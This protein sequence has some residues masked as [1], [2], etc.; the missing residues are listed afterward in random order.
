LINARAFFADATVF[1]AETHI[2]YAK[3]IAIN[4]MPTL[5]SNIVVQSMILTA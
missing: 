3:A 2:P 4:P 5:S 1:S